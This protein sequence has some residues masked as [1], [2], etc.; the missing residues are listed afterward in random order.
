MDYH[1][2]RPQSV[3]HASPKRGVSKA[4]NGI[5][6]IDLPGPMLDPEADADRVYQ[7][8]IE[9]TESVRQAMVT[10]R[11]DLAKAVRAAG[12]WYHEPTPRPTVAH[13]KRAS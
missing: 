9:A 2:L 5:V 1:R 12:I 13:A 4:G 10:T 6:T 8:L 7:L 11:N 3:P